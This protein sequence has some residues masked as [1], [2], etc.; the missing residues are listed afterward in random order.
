MLDI[1][2][3]SLYD[4]VFDG[5]PVTT[6]VLGEFLKTPYAVAPCPNVQFIVLTGAPPLHA[7]VTEVRMGE[8]KTRG[9]GV[10]WPGARV[11]VGVAVGGTSMGGWV[12]VLV[13]RG[14]GVLVGRGVGV[15]V[16]V[17]ARQA[18]IEQLYCPTGQV[19][20][21]VQVFDPSSH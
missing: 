9:V 4:V 7:V 18:K 5:R 8:V 15:G 17:G 11:G 10:G 1:G 21:L 3:V 19:D 20:P 6:G 14:V 16:L 12:G 2:V 13:G